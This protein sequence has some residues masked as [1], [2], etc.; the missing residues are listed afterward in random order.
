MQQE[1]Q[2]F[3]FFY[4]IFL[5]MIELIYFTFLFMNTGTQ[6]II[7]SSSPINESTIAQSRIRILKETNGIKTIQISAKHNSSVEIILKPSEFE[8][9]YHYI[10]QY[11]S[12]N[13]SIIPYGSTCTGDLICFSSRPNWGLWFLQI[14][15]DSYVLF[16]LPLEKVDLFLKE[17][18]NIW[19]QL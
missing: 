6:S 10:T 7:S 17:I 3:K 15:L 4:I 9:I 8:H 13:S 16:H 18:D 12:T 1:Q 5:I 2:F 14:N 19:Y 11:F